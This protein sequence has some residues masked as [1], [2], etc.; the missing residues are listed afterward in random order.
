KEYYICC[1][2]Y[3]WSQPAPV[4]VDSK[5]GEYVPVNQN[6]VA[7][8]DLY[9]MYAPISICYYHSIDDLSCSMNIAGR[10]QLNGWSAI[11]DRMLIW[12]YSCNYWNFLWWFPNIS[13]LKDNLQKYKDLGVV[14]V[15][16][17]GPAFDKNSYHNNLLTYLLSKLMWDIDRNVY[18]LVEE[19]NRYYFEEGAEYMNDFINLLEGHFAMLNI[20]TDLYENTPTF[21][22]AETY[23][24]ELLQNAIELTNKGFEQINKSQ[25]TDKEKSDFETRFTRARIQA[26]YMILRNIDLYGYSATAKEEFIDNF[27][28]TTDKLGITHFSE[29]KTANQL[30][31]QYGY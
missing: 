29:R 19:F 27:F 28:R 6:V 30:K 16:T 31:E 20:H 3:Q 1:F 23:P 17:Q 7:H 18:D 22:A 9:V 15:R 14:M 24:L 2:S 4:K 8:K 11:T 10:E 26:E 25:R 12:D 5:T 21:L 13:V